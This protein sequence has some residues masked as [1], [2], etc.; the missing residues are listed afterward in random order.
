MAAIGGSPYTLSLGRKVF[1]RR[2]PCWI[3]GF[4]YC[5]RSYLRAMAHFGALCIVDVVI[6]ALGV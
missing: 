5:W 1:G 3:L 6:G 4:A 2:C